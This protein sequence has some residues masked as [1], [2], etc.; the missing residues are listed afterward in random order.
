M[1]VTWHVD[2]TG[3]ARC[4]VLNQHPLY[5]KKNN[6]L[7]GCSNYL[8]LQPK[9]SFDQ[10]IFFRNYARTGLHNSFCGVVQVAT[11]KVEYVLLQ[12]TVGLLYP[13]YLFRQ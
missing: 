8:L 4:L 11:R 13:G 12:E 2:H 6:L 3:I 7:L 5:H 1:Q 10:R 9:F